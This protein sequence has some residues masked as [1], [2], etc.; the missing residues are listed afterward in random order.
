MIKDVKELIE[1]LNKIPRD[2]PIYIR[3]S[4]TGYVGSIQIKRVREDRLDE[5]EVDRGES[6]TGKSDY[7]ELF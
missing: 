6:K 5:H 4:P 1:V 7:V 2:L 3:H